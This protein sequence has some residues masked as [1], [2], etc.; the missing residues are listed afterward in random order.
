[1]NEDLLKKIYEQKG[2]KDFGT[3]DKFKTDMMSS[4]DIRKKVFEQK[5]FAEHGTYEQFEKDLAIQPPTLPPL[6]QYQKGPVGVARPG[7]M[8][9]PGQDDERLKNFYGKDETKSPMHKSA[10]LAGNPKLSMSIDPVA[11]QELGVAVAQVGSAEKEAKSATLVN[12]EG[13]VLT[14]AKSFYGDNLEKKKEN[15]SKNPQI[16]DAE[17]SLEALNIYEEE[18]KYLAKR[19]RERLKAL[20]ADKYSPAQIDKAVNTYTA[21]SLMGQTEEAQAFITKFPELKDDPNLNNIFGVNDK[22]RELSLARM[23]V[24]KNNPEWVKYNT[25][26]IPAKQKEINQNVEKFREEN[27]DI[28]LWGQGIPMLVH[29]N[30]GQTIKGR[31]GGWAKNL[32]EF[33]PFA[34]TGAV[35]DWGR[36]MMD[37]NPKSSDYQ[38]KAIEEYKKVQGY[39]VV[40]DGDKISYVRDPKTGFIVEPTPEKM[41]TIKEEA[42]GK[43]SQKRFNAKPFV[44]QT[45]DV[46]L[47]MAPIVALTYATGGTL[48]GLLGSATAR[49]IGVVAGSALQ[50]R[51]DLMDQMLLHPDIS[52]TE[53]EVYTD[54]IGFGIGLLSLINPMEAPGLAKALPGILKK[55]SARLLNKEITKGQFA[56]EVTKDLGSLSAKETTEELLQEWFQ[57]GAQKGIDATQ[58]GYGRFDIQAPTGDDMLEIGLVSSAVAMLGGAGSIRASRNAMIDEA[59][60]T[61]LDKPKIVSEYL[62]GMEDRANAI[63]DEA[64]KEQALDHIE[65]IRERWANIQTNVD[66]VKGLDKKKRGKLAGLIADSNALE[67]EASGITNSTLLAAK[68]EEIKA[69]NDEI[70]A[71]IT[72]GPAAAPTTAAAT[73][74][75]TEETEDKIRK[76]ADS[77]SLLSEKDVDVE[78]DYFEEGQEIED[79]SRFEGGKRGKI[80]SVNNNLIQPGESK[81]SVHSIEIEYE[82]GRKATKVV[83]RKTPME[84]GIKVVTPNKK[85]ESLDYTPLDIKP[86]APSVDALKDVE[87]TKEAFKGIEAEDLKPLVE[88]AGGKVGPAGIATAYHAAKADDSNPELVA[89]V[90]KLLGTKPAPKPAPPPTPKTDQTIPEGYVSYEEARKIVPTSKFKD[91]PEGEDEGSMEARSRAL[92]EQENTPPTFQKHPV[93]TRAV[94]KRGE[95]YELRD[96]PFDEL[97]VNDDGGLTQPTVDKYAKWLQEGNE[98]PPITGVENFV[99][100]GGKVKVSDGRH[101]I[102][103]AK[104]AGLKTVPVWVNLTDPVTQTRPVMIEDDIKQRKSKSTTTASIPVM[105]TKKMEADLRERGYTQSQIDKLT[106]QEANDILNKPAVA[107]PPKSK[108]RSD[109]LKNRKKDNLTHRD[110]KRVLLESRSDGLTLDESYEKAG[111][112]KIGQIWVSPDIS[113]AKLEMIPDALWQAMEDAGIGILS[114]T[115]AET[116]H[117]VAREQE[118]DDRTTSEI[119]LSPHDLEKKGLI[120]VISHEIGHAVYRTLS[121]DQKKGFENFNAVSAYVEGL[122]S[123]VHHSGASNSEENFVENFAAD[124]TARLFGESR[125]EVQD[126]YKELLDTINAKY[127]KSDKSPKLQPDED[128][129]GQDPKAGQEDNAKESDDPLD[130]FDGDLARFLRYNGIELS[131]YERAVEND[132]DLVLTVEEINDLPA[133]EKG[134][135]Y[136]GEDSSL[137]DLK[138]KDGDIVRS[139]YSGKMFEVRVLSPEEAKAR[140]NAIKWHY[141]KDVTYYEITNIDDGSSRMD[142]NTDTYQLISRGDGTLIY[143]KQEEP[144]PKPA[145]KPSRYTKPKPEAAPKPKSKTEEKK[146][147]ID[148]EIDDIFDY[149]KKL[150]IAQTPEQQAEDMRMGIR[151]IN[152]YF[153]KGF[154]TM[155]GIIEDMITRMDSEVAERVLPYVK[156]AYL[157]IQREVSD[158]VLDQMDDVKAVR[159]ITVQEVVKPITQ[160][161]AENLEEDETDLEQE[162]AD[163]EA[164]ST[165]P[166]AII[167][168]NEVALN[169]AEVASTPEEIAASLEAIENAIKVTTSK[170]GQ[171]KSEYNTNGILHETPSVEVGKQAAKDVRKHAKEIARLTGWE[172]EKVYPNIAPAGGEVY[173]IFKIPG[174][175]LQARV[176]LNF[177][178]DY[179][180]GGGYDNYK[181]NRVGVSIQESAKGYK[182]LSHNHQIPTSRDAKSIAMELFKRAMPYIAERVTSPVEMPAG[183]ESATSGPSLTAGSTKSPNFTTKPSK[184][185]TGTKTKPDRGSGKDSTRLDSTHPDFQQDLLY[186]PETERDT[187]TDSTGETGGILPD[188]GGT[189]RKP[190]TRGGRGNSQGTTL[191][192]TFPLEETATP[193]D[194][195]SVRRPKNYRAA[196]NAPDPTT[197]N[198]KQRFKANLDALKTLRTILAEDRQATEAEQEILAKYVGWGALKVVTFDEAN[199]WPT[200]WESFRPLVTELKAVVAELEALGMKGLLRSIQGSIKNAHFTGPEVIR[201]MYSILYRM[202]FN[203]GKVLEPSAGIGNFF[204]SMP[205]IMAENSQLF[206]VELETLTGNIL[207]K[208]YPQSITQIKGYQQANYPRNNFDLVVSNIPFGDYNVV[209]VPK[210]E[211]AAVKKAASKIHNFFF[212]KGLDHVKEG[213]LIAFVT[214]AGVLDSRENKWI[215]EH[216]NQNADFLGAVRLPSTAFKGVAG[217]EVTTDIIFLRKNTTGEKNNTPFINSVPVTVKHKDNGSPVQIYV[218][219]YFLGDQ[220]SQNMLGTLAAGGLQATRMTLIPDPGFSIEEGL[221]QVE[222]NFPKDVFAPMATQ[223]QSVIESEEEYEEINIEQ[224]SYFKDKDGAYV[225]IRKDGPHA[226]AKTHMAKVPLFLELRDTLKK[227]YQ[228]EIDSYSDEEIDANRIK[229]NDAYE[230][231]VKKFKDLH[232]RNNQAFVLG[233]IFGHNVMSLELV[234]EDTKEITKASILSKRVINPPTRATSASS[235]QD[236]ISI[237]IN[238]TGHVDLERIADLLDM[239]PDVLFEEYYGVIFRDENGNIVSSNE[240]LSGNV[241]QKLALAKELAEKDSLYDANVRALEAVIPEDIPRPDINLGARYVPTSIYED[242]VKEVYGADSDIHIRYSPGVDKFAV[243]GSGTNVESR[244]TFAVLHDDGYVLMDGYKL[245]ETLLHSQDPLIYD[246]I[247]NPDGSTTQKINKKYSEKAAEKARDLQAEF[248]AW[249]WQDDARADQLARIYNDLY[250]TSINRSYAGLKMTIPGMVDLELRE[251]QD[252]S[253]TRLVINNGGVIDHIV[254]SGKTFIMIAT[255]LKMKELGVA[256]RPTIVALKS[257]IS[258]IVEDTKKHFPNA[259]VLAPKETDFSPKNRKA[260]LSKI[261]NNDWDLVVMTHD[262]FKKIPQDPEFIEQVI[263]DEIQQLIDEVSALA[264]ERGVESSRI[265]TAL[266]GRIDKLREKLEKLRDTGSIDKEIL[267]FRQ[268]GIDHIFVDESQQFKNLEFSTKLGR[269]AGLGNPTGS[270][271]AFNMLTAIRTLQAMHGGDKGT[272]FLSGTPI[273]NSMVEMYLILKYLRPNKMKEVGYNTF[274]SWVVNSAEKSKEIEYTVTGSVKPKTRFRKYI[275]IP[276]LA[277]LYTEIADVRNDEN[278]YVEKPKIRGGS[279]ELV[280]SVQ[281]DEQQDFTRRLREFAEQPHGNRDG[282]LIGLG[283]LTEGQQGSAMLIVTGLSSKMAIDMRLVDRNASFNPDGKIANAAKNVYEEWKNSHDIKGTQLV[284]SDLGTPKTG[285]VVDDMRSYL[286]DEKNIIE[287]DL[288]KI[289]GEE[290]KPKKLTI[291]EMVKALGDELE[292]SESEIAEMMIESKA[293]SA[294]SF[295]VYNETK[296]LLVE[297]G[298]PAHEIAFIHDYKTDAAKK[299]LFKKVNKGEVRVLIGSTQKLGTGVNVQRRI[300]ALHHIDAQWNPAAMAQRNGRGI[301]QKNLNNEVAIYNY[302]TKGT[303][304]AYKYQ[305]IGGKQRFIDQVK[306]GATGER[307]Y[308]EGEGEEMSATM[309]SAIISENELLI[310]SISTN[311]KVERLKRSKQSHIAEQISLKNKIVALEKELALDKEWVKGLAKDIPVVKANSTVDEEGKSV[312]NVVITFFGKDQIPKDSAER[313]TLIRAIETGFKAQNPPGTKVVI[314]KAGGLDITLEVKLIRTTDIPLGYKDTEVRLVGQN[315]Y[316]TSQHSFSLA[317]LRVVD[318]LI[319]AQEQ[320]KKEEDKLERYKSKIGKEWD[321]DDELI[322]AVKR[323]GEIDA[324]LKRQADEAEAAAEAANA[325]NATDEDDGYDEDRPSFSMDSLPTVMPDLVNG[326]YSPLEKIIRESK[327]DKLPVKQWIEKFAKGE[328]AKWTGLTEWL[329]AQEG[330]VTKSDILDFL[331]DN[332]V[333]IKE[334][335]KGSGQENPYGEKSRAEQMEDIRNKIRSLPGNYDLDR[336]MDGDWALMRD[337]ELIDDTDESVPEEIQRLGMEHWELNDYDP[338]DDGDGDPQ[339]SGYTLPGE[340]TNYKEVLVTMPKVTGRWNIIDEI[341]A[342]YNTVDTEAEAEQLA[343]N[344]SK[345]QGKKF[346]IREQPQK[347]FQSQHWSEPN[348]LVHLRMD[349]RID[350]NGDKVLFL[351]E[352]QSDWAQ[353]GRKQGFKLSPKEQAEADRLESAYKAAERET[354]KYWDA[355]SQNLSVGSLVEVDPVFKEIFNKEQDAW[356]AYQAALKGTVITSVAPAPFVTDTSAWT[357]LA[358]K[359][360]TKEAVKQGATKIAWTTGEQQAS[361]YNLSAQVDRIVVSEPSE[362]DKDRNGDY[363]KRLKVHF[364]S[365]K[366]FPMAVNR[367]GR[368]IEGTEAVYGKNLGEVV[369]EELAE[370]IMAVKEGNVKEFSGLDFELGSHGMTGYYGDPAK[371]KLG[372]LGNVAK[373][374]FLDVKTTEITNEVG[375]RYDKIEIIENKWGDS[376][377][378]ENALVLNGRIVDNDSVY[379]AQGVIDSIKEQNID[380]EYPEFLIDDF[381]RT[382]SLKN[383]HSESDQIEKST[384]HSVTITPELANQVKAQGLPLFSIQAAETAIKSGNPDPNAQ[385]IIKL[386]DAGATVEE[387]LRQFADLWIDLVEKQSKPFINRGLE[388]IKGTEYDT[389]DPRKDLANAIAEKAAKSKKDNKLINWVKDFWKRVGKIMK[390]NV[391]PEQLQDMT[392]GEYLDIA[393][394]QM[395]YGNEVYM[396][397]LADEAKAKTDN[398]PVITPAAPPDNVAKYESLSDDEV[399]SRPVSSGKPVPP[400]PLSNDERYLFEGRDEDAQGVVIANPKGPTME[401]MLQGYAGPH[402]R[403]LETLVLLFPTLKTAGITI[404]VHESKDS[405]ANA[406]VANGGTASQAVKSGGFYHN[407]EVHINLAKADLKENTALHEAFHPI[408][409]E[410]LVKNKPAFKRF[411]AEILA[412]PEM[413]RRYLDEFSQNY[414]YLAGQENA[415]EEEMLVEASADIVMKR[416]LR[417]LNDMPDKLFDRILKYIKDVLGDAYGKLA[418]FISDKESFAVFANGLAEAISKGMVVPM[419]PEINDNIRTIVNESIQHSKQ[420]AGNLFGGQE[421]TDLFGLMNNQRTLN[422]EKATPEA[423]LRQKYFDLGYPA[424]NGQKSNLTPDQYYQVRTP[425]FKAWF[426]D[427]EGDPAGASKVVDENGEPLVVYHGTAQY[428]FQEFKGNKPIFFS[429]SKGTADS[430][431]DKADGQSKGTYG[432]FLNSRNI[433]KIDANGSDF[434]SIVVEEDTMT[435]K[436]TRLS[437]SGI[438]ESVF[439]FR[440]PSIVTEKQGAGKTDGVVVTNVKDDLLGSTGKS[441]SNVYVVVAPTQIKSATDNTGAFDVNNPDIRFS[442]DPYDPVTS[443]EFKTWFGGSKVVDENGAP[444]VVY[445][446]STN[447]EPITKFRKGAHGLLGPGTYFTNDERYATDYADKRGA[448]NGQVI[449]AYLHMQN[450]YIVIGPDGSV[451]LLKKLYG[452][453]VARNRQSKQGNINYLVTARDTKKIRD[454]GHDGIIYKIKDIPDAYTEYVVFEPTQVKSA[455]KNTGQFSARNPDIRFSMEPDTVKD[456][457]G[458][459]IV[460]YHGT[461]AEFSDFDS[462]KQNSVTGHGDFGKGFYLSASPGVGRY[463][464]LK[465]EE[466]RRVV[467][468]FNV[469]AKKPFEINI[470]DE[471]FDEDTKKRFLG[472][473]YIQDYERDIIKD[474]TKGELPFAYKK[475]SK[476]IGDRRLSDIFQENGFDAVY[477]NRTL[478]NE[479]TEKAE[480][481]VFD[482]TQIKTPFQPPQFSSHSEAKVARIKK[483]L[484]HDILTQPDYNFEPIVEMLIR[485]G[486]LTKA[487]GDELLGTKRAAEKMGF[488]GDKLLGMLIDMAGLRHLHRMDVEDNLQVKNANMQQLMNDMR[489][490]KDEGLLDGL[491]DKYSPGTIKEWIEEVMASGL[492]HPA[493]IIAKYRRANKAGDPVGVMTIIATS[494]AFA[495]LKREATFYKNLVDQT[496]DIEAS[497]QLQY[498]RA[499]QYELA[500]LAKTNGSH[501]GAALGIRSKL[502]QLAGLT[503]ES[504]MAQIEEINESKA[505]K[506]IEI[507]QATKDEVKRLVDLINTQ[508]EQMD[509]LIAQS[510]ASNSKKVAAEKE[511]NRKAQSALEAR[512]I[513]TKAEALEHLRRLRGIRASFSLMLSAD[514]P[515]FNVLDIINELVKIA[516]Q[517]ITEEGGRAGFKNVVAR[518]QSY[519][520]TITEEQVY[521]ALVSTTAFAKQKALSEYAKRQAETRKQVKDIAKVEKIVTDQVLDLLRNKKVPTE[522]KMAE[523]GDLLQSIEKG[524]YMYKSNAELYVKWL[525]DVQLIREKYALAFLHPNDPVNNPPKDDDQILGELINAVLTLK[526]NKLYDWMRAQEAELLRQK[527]MIDSGRISELIAEEDRDHIELPGEFSKITYE[528]GV[529]TGT[530]PTTFDFG[531]MDRQI[532]ENKKELEKVKS[533]F[534]KKG[535]L[536]QYTY[537]LYRLPRGTLGTAQAMIDLSMIAI[538]GFKASLVAMVR[539]PGALKQA[540]TSSLKTFYDEMKKDPG[541]SNEIHYNMTQNKYYNILQAAGLDLTSPDSH[542][543][544]NEMVSQDD[545]FDLLHDKTKGR[546]NIAAK[547]ARGALGIRR[548]LKNASNASFATYLNILSFEAAV[549]YIEKVKAVNDGKMP[550]VRELAVKAHEINSSTGRTKRAP[551]ATEGAA[552]FF[553]APKLYLSQILNVANIVADPVNFAGNMTKLQIAIAKGDEAAIQKHREMVRVYGHRAVNSLIFATSSVGLYMIRVM[554]AKWQ[555]G[556]NA[557][558]NTNIAKPSFLKINCGELTLDPTGN[559]RQWLALGARAWAGFRGDPYLDYMGRP[560]TTTEQ[561]MDLMQYKFNPLVSTGFQMWDGTDFLGR[562]RQPDDQSFLMWQSRAE[563]LLDH[564]KPIGVGNV[565]EIAG[566]KGMDGKLPTIISKPMVMI[567]AIQGFGVTRIDEEEENARKAIEK[568]VR[569]KKKAAKQ[570]EDVGQLRTRIGNLK[571]LQ[572]SFIYDI[573]AEALDLTP[574]TVSFDGKTYKVF[575]RND[576]PGGNKKDDDL[577]TVKTTQSGPNK[578]KKYFERIPKDKKINYN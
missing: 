521:E 364:K 332:R 24:A 268:I 145:K 37:M 53:A 36:E 76:G 578:G 563:V 440:F 139:S 121:E 482:K 446:G 426:G 281:N 277:Q 56:W 571:E 190:T 453:G 26:K 114:F 382:K 147:D 174:V 261:Q 142:G 467:K 282:N 72:P 384:Q 218:N 80:V 225:V 98:M 107:K 386:K 572:G 345:I 157:A 421:Q 326:F 331:E 372:I 202:G 389:G 181:L 153:Q 576:D 575:K 558:V 152:L 271:R 296:R 424:P 119:Q 44:G 565:V 560:V 108:T 497:T 392:V 79:D 494:I 52:P 577:Y 530:E 428:G 172:L 305:L 369:G 239:D 66:S 263:N 430:Y 340:K 248:D 216:L 469:I 124:L 522:S 134:K 211:S 8:A 367:D 536:E 549:S 51:G 230:A 158:E 354:S 88:L 42:K 403:V 275:N 381:E 394:T 180:S 130:E 105:I 165:D 509:K 188:S 247:K 539:Q 2:F 234:N 361:R 292:F 321:K 35:R 112:T 276:E 463:Y 374:L 125:F 550:S 92:R 19:S 534:R 254:G 495:E 184:D 131:E 320:I 46:L 442:M 393:A 116:V 527:E 551:G 191:P 553:W 178:P 387:N 200:S 297:K 143:T 351:E 109:A 58:P 93:G 371:G 477:V 316:K 366:S 535:T 299:A 170:L 244:T 177:K 570:T 523:F 310:E 262:Q 561:I 83:A 488:S 85:G 156:S 28:P 486:T 500:N 212:A 197:F 229:L 161:Q 329:G 115:N 360:A 260:L 293:S 313:N 220:G 339:Y 503:Y 479:T 246:T 481:V 13:D 38:G 22:L 377:V 416:V 31:I 74:D 465:F 431:Q 90:E 150:S 356:Q 136:R 242:F 368:I 294:T 135:I 432:V 50:V 15:Y 217:T 222:Q 337:G 251:H 476:E 513:M 203:G 554:L 206:G 295:N 508:Q 238:E 327:A 140:R 280:V 433:E 289:F 454:L 510:D 199:N 129:K 63:T 249:K 564:L 373:S 328:E 144:A 434:A 127:G 314:G 323:K 380:G 59:L 448:G 235:I 201:G 236:A 355:N 304:D 267:N 419:N 474:A 186:G 47:D 100:Y 64:A 113:D 27:K 192:G 9:N 562:R 452:E 49:G 48:S 5:G 231:F 400:K 515:E 118:F 183:L 91:I 6:Q 427:W 525:N 196:S 450:P 70:K 376:V 505:G 4:P 330:S 358:L 89:A 489:D 540:F 32:A 464:S 546:K 207:K 141:D 45:A 443:P 86:P 264:S 524:I 257:T 3:F 265:R 25:E 189:K 287:E 348:I 102:A 418:D 185:A 159:A 491:L 278:L 308:T 447:F 397:L 519:D 538:Q 215:R 132:P 517:E 343:K 291:K 21:L 133:H 151:L 298:I 269:V 547:V 466:G 253:V 456:D 317:L 7:V 67:S 187:G 483:D 472:L 122:Q 210:T 123:G 309:W 556:E 110:R 342:V 233:D 385:L 167:T 363:H 60:S 475:I 78:I 388:L 511:Y 461:G 406:V 120:H 194:E 16:A 412:D 111:Y 514:A 567:E 338:D 138:A 407:K 552:Y 352:V 559:H 176:Y 224:D 518:V 307:T 402:R 504:E 104:K 306:T 205:G 227:Q 526:D 395:I 487:D 154:Y 284:F 241:K 542:H 318:G 279:A 417:S 350:A 173:L 94:D 470:S 322:A 499:A 34:E 555:C 61:A 319:P 502:L 391:T 97:V 14:N 286:A 43:E 439:G 543:F 232:H 548:K 300:V 221:R 315:E 506:G 460:F 182:T 87:S 445:H 285:R 204:G 208:L 507:D 68:K 353:N 484:A 334:V 493:E 365:D 81:P 290:D 106:P 512:P 405:Y 168:A 303:L 11:Q 471:V 423:L 149:F 128:N 379:N 274:D 370:K 252:E 444:L 240:Y 496:G 243:K 198:Q 485:K 103:A 55:N 155:K 209:G 341:G 62:G 398:E 574:H 457:T 65:R 259:K 501:A 84:A 148:K 237:S 401:R 325:E 473:R 528:D 255:A 420:R 478:G 160:D 462:S 429:D 573:P 409:R 441:P 193:K 77:E 383:I 30:V 347:D 39:D 404:T 449:D 75:V 437:V 179:S 362:Y 258:D 166:E 516:H 146:S 531:Q 1:M 175:S 557:S 458:K 396:E 82:D 532:R 57:Y 468:E 266:E 71:L 498:V 12:M 73:S 228:L 171:I 213:G 490:V 399:A 569:D 335:V 415:I 378:L 69:I 214:T 492:A 422:Q 438:Y 541:L 101:R 414:Q 357:K 349:T 283:D 99:A 312:P 33:V 533:K 288:E 435:A 54:A 336:Q 455:S 545:A 529:A 566:A 169:E 324:E 480:V 10:L 346:S 273:S 226:I 195:V 390:I 40:F 223:D 436:K 117:G 272:T 375:K 256:N 162:E 23:H 163:S 410:L 311:E 425:E 544:I 29:P 164:E 219:E 20:N 41:K 18:A 333:E 250:N 411:M 302:A 17:F 137:K 520:P 459:P 408:I 270:G 344:V 359:V 413:R 95:V 537:W 126:Q 451:D 96:L 301:R 245:L 568:E